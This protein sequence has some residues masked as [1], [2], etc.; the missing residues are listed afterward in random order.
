[1]ADQAFTLLAQNSP[2]FIGIASIEGQTLYVNKAGRRL[3]GLEGAD[4]IART[5]LFEYI[6]EE[7]R[8][9]MRERIMP[10]LLQNGSWKG[11]CRLSHF[12]TGAP[13]PVEV[14]FFIIKDLSSGRPVAINT[15]MRE[16]IGRARR[17]KMPLGDTEIFPK[18]I[19]CRV[20]LG[21]CPKGSIPLS[22]TIV[23]AYSKLSRR[24][25]DRNAPSILFAVNFIEQNIMEQLSLERIAASVNMSKYHFARVFKSLVG[26]SPMFFVTSVRLENAGEILKRSGLSILEVAYSV[27]FNSVSHFA[28]QF[29]K[30][31]GKTPSDYRAH[32]AE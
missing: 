22:K 21:D 15:I 14:H 29:R 32:S 13:I 30:F 10:D 5:N 8:R 4:D 20:S 7:D 11:E 23:S 31:T 2:D 16:I 12:K 6:M 28:G 17:R 9:E 27:G 24:P 1:M 3:A 19:Y 26:M 25:C 18:D